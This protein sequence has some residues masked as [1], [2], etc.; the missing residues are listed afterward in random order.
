MNSERVG[1]VCSPILRR[2]GDHWHDVSD[3]LTI[4]RKLENSEDGA[5]A[6]S[7]ENGGNH[8]P[9]TIHDG[10]PMTFIIRP[11]VARPT[12]IW[13]DSSGGE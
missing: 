10:S 8:E 11:S 7:S 9:L 5:T 1:G 6:E 4:C 12:G 2:K 13:F 3:Q